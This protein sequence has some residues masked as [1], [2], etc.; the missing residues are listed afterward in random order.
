MTQHTILLPHEEAAMRLGKVHDLMQD[1]GVDAL[2]LGSPANIFYMTG[3]VFNGYVYVAPD[4]SLTCFVRRP[5]VLDGPATIYIHKPENIPAQLE[6]HGIAAPGSLALECGL[7]SYAT[8][9]RL[10]KAL[11]VQTFADADTVMARAR[12]VKTADEIA[13]I[14]ACAV[15][16]DRIYGMIPR[17]YRPGMTDLE[18]Q[19]EIERATRLEGSIGILR[20]NGDDLEINM[21]SVLTGENA[22]TPS[23]YDFAMGGAGT[24]PALPLGAD[25]TVIRPGCPVMV[26]MNGCFNGYMTDMTRIFAAGTL[27]PEV[28]DAHALSIEICRAIARAAVP[29]TPCADL[30]E[31]AVSM[32]TDAG[33][34]HRLMGHRSQAGFVGHG[35]GIAVNELPVLQPR[36]RDAI[37][38]GMVI[39]VEPKFVLPRV[40]AVGIENTY[41]AT[42]QGLEC[43]T[44]AP[45][46]IVELPL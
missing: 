14:R 38:P 7:S 43:L 13:A 37:A 21:G 12:M 35:I 34:N 33:M 25:G 18:L 45:E 8:V 42:E 27:A 9:M 24:S 6:S 40:G 31:L 16:H 11:G 29:G 3:R 10:A 22:D 20:T 44:H 39:A 28:L 4:G 41:L 2:L 17:L 19:I 46:E 1:T 15:R 23:P 36:S 30:Y 26:D 5:N 32:A